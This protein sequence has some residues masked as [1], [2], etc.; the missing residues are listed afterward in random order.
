MTNRRSFFGLLAVSPVAAVGAVK[1]ISVDVDEFPVL[2]TNAIM[3]F[4]FTLPA[5]V[6]GPE[7]WLEWW[8]KNKAGIR[9]RVA[10]GVFDM[11]R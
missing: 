6:H 7:Q 11:Q 10:A 8:E 5:E 1:A 3:E 4:E 2:P 9:T